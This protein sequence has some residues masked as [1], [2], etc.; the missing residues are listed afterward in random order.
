M[1][2][3]MK[4]FLIAML[5]CIPC[6]ANSCVATGGPYASLAASAGHWTGSGCTGGSY[7]PTIGDTENLATNS[8]TLTVA[9]GET[10][11]VGTSVGSY[12]SYISSIVN[13]GTA[14]AGNGTVTVNIIGGTPLVSAQTAHGVLTGGVISATVDFPLMWYT[15]ASVAPTAT[16]TCSP[17][18]AGAVAQVNW[19]QG[20]GVAA[21]NTG[22]TGKLIVAGTLNPRGAITYSGGNTVQGNYVEMAAGGKINFDNSHATALADGSFPYYVGTPDATSTTHNQRTWGINASS[23]CS[24]ISR[25]TLTATGSAAS[26]SSAN[27]SESVAPQIQYTDIT[28][29]GDAKLPW[30]DS[31]LTTTG[32]F[33]DTWN[34]CTSCGSYWDN[35]GYV[36][37]TTW[38]HSYN[39]RTNSILPN[40]QPAVEFPGFA[41]LFNTNAPVWVGNVSDIQSLDAAPM[42]NFTFTDNLFLYNQ[43]EGMFASNRVCAVYTSNFAWKQLPATEDEDMNCNTTRAFTFWDPTNGSL[44]NPHDWNTNSSNLTGQPFTL[45][46]SV[47]EA[48]AGLTGD[49]GEWVSFFAANTLVG[50]TQN[51]IMLHGSD[52]YSFSEFAASTPSTGHFQQLN[53]YWYGVYSGNTAGNGQ[54]ALQDL[55]EA[56]TAIPVAAVT[57]NIGYNPGTTAAGV[58]GGY[59]ALAITGLTQNSIVSADYNLNFNLEPTKASCGGC[60]FQGI[61]YAANWSSAAA[62]GAHDLTGVD[63][64][65]IDYK[66]SILVFDTQ[67]LGVAVAPQWVSG[68]YSIGA[69]VSNT[70]STVAFGR[71]VN[72]RCIAA[73]CGTQQPGATPNTGHAYWEYNVINEI[74]TRLGIHYTTFVDG[75]L[76]MDEDGSCGAANPCS[77]ITASI[78]WIR[79][80]HVSLNPL[81]WTADR[82]DGLDIG[83]SQRSMLQHMPMLM[84]VQ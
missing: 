18:C 70:V 17:A 55:E 20:S 62:R 31:T 66:R 16:F 50:T 77:V 61:A 84:F 47:S 57:G 42:L 28:G 52:G 27:A 48:G 19:S 14:P 33:L 65:L 5:M 72:Y 30:A 67:Y 3:L 13:I 1:R 58:H 51:S 41:A 2:N 78:N 6:F 45:D 79:Q 4:T 81:T 53:N 46:K 40:S 39:T 10:Q 75:N 24:A 64:Q 12:F 32:G 15:V 76:G 8:V 35:S 68:A 71:A 26:I 56:G 44:A 9:T 74:R 34:S 60:N 63:P 11:T 80:G 29:L 54:F 37:V 49:S 69:V 25:C 22:T 36:G 7:I 59:L 43:A 82:L 83:P 73:G 23:P 38:V 21:V